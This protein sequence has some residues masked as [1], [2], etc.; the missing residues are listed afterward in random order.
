MQYVEVLI[1]KQTRFA[2][3]YRYK[4]V[5][6]GKGLVLDVSF[7]TKRGV[8]VVPL[9]IVFFIIQMRTSLP[10]FVRFRCPISMFQAT[11]VLPS[12]LKKK[13]QVLRMLQ[14]EATLT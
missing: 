8:V 9:T 2:E 6:K 12:H 5:K 4:N 14:D 13:M 3:D 1:E 11:E 10:A 7:F